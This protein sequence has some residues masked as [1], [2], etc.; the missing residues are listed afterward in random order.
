MESLIRT[1]CQQNLALV[2]IP[3]VNGKPTKAPIHRNWNKPRSLANPNGYSMNSDD[4]LDCKRINL[5]LYHAAS[6]T[7]ALD[8]DDLVQA[9]VLFEET[10]DISI[11]DWLNDPHRFEIKSPKPNRGKLLYKLPKGF[12]ETRHVQLKWDKRVIFELRS[13]NCQDVICGQHPEGGAYEILGNPAAIPKAPAILLDMLQNWEAWN[14]L[15]NSVLTPEKPIPITPTPQQD[16]ELQPGQRNPIAEFNGNY[17]VSDILLRNG[18]QE[19]KS[20]NGKSKGRW[21]HPNSTTKQPGTVIFTDDTN[22]LERAYSHGGDV[23]SDKFYHDAFDCYRLL[24]CDGDINKALAWNPELTKHNQRLFK[25]KQTEIATQSIFKMSSLGNIPIPVETTHNAILDNEHQYCQVDLIQ[26]V[27]NNHLI[28]QLSQYVSELTYLPASTVMLM[29]MAVF[30]SIATRRYAVRYQNGKKLPIGLYVLAEQP[31]GASKSRC[32]DLFQEPFF[33]AREQATAHIQCQ[34]TSLGE[35]E[36]L[37][38]GEEATLKQLKKPLVPLFISNTTSEGLENTL[39]SSKGFFSNVASELGLLNSLLGM[40]YGKGENNNDIVLNGFDGGYIGNCRVTRQGYAGRVIGS[41][42][43]FAQ[44]GTI[45]KVLAASNGTGLS[46]RFLML[47][48]NHQLGTRDHTVNPEHNVFL[49]GRYSQACCFAENLLI[50][51]RQVDE[52]EDLQISPEG[53]LRIANYRNQ[54]EPHLK[55]GG[56]YAHISLRGAASKMNMQI[57]K[58]AAILH[59]LDES[60][61]GQT[62]IFDQH[63]DSAIRIANELL[64]ANLKLCQ[65]KGIIGRKA[66]FTAILNYLTA[67]PGAKSE[68]DIINSLRSTLPFKDQTGNKSDAIKQALAEMTSQRLLNKLKDQNGKVSYCLAQ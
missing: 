10:A 9:V 39:H 60:R 59:L 65:D 31:S 4:F 2:P 15:F 42:V 52:L 32:L 26:H 22:G 20:R 12:K 54:I 57:M 29:G 66:E 24:E 46:E 6:G 5:G 18:Y 38:P 16:T 43:C 63:V 35:K 17:T 23:L 51:P 67:R 7:I 19:I 14:Q 8:L 37:T 44:Q 48:E 25:Q 61:A 3:P 11:T 45:E 13:G 49:E 1:L 55:D 21:L 64:E 30:S 40:S 28:K 34:I 41:I 58:I 62:L 53:Y 36:S 50:N 68:R 56:K 47:A 27:D 33:K